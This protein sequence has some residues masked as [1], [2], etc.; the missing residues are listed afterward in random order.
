MR[1]EIPLANSIPK[2]SK[3]VFNLNRI[4]GVVNKKLEM[5]RFVI[6]DHFNHTL[7]TKFLPLIHFVSSDL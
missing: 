7:I 2:V 3:T 5:L 4:G 6:T 1:G